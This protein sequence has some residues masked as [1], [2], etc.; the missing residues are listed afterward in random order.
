MTPTAYTRAMLARRPSAAA[1]PAFGHVDVAPGGRAQLHDVVEKLVTLVKARKPVAFHPDDIPDD[2]EILVAELKGFDSWFQP[3]APWSL[4]RAVAEIRATGS[5]LTLKASGITQGAWSFYVIRSKV[6]QNDSVVVRAKSPSW[7]L[8]GESRLLTKFV[9]SEL[10]LVQEPL[11]AFDRTADLVVIGSKVFVLD[12]RACE[13]L[14]VDADAVKRRAPQAVAT[15]K[16]KMDAGLTS[17][18]VDAVVRVCSND[19]NIARRVERLTRDGGLSTVTAT[20]VRSA[21]PDAGL[22]ANDF[23]PSGPLQAVTD[24]HAT[25]LV[26]I[27]A[28]LYYQPRF[29]TSPRRVAAYRQVR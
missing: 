2:G 12:P 22:T 25:V 26:D 23:G 4:E 19:A 5:P 14:L 21:L 9:G 6:G 29:S 10:K 8:K 16:Q 1:V 13:R 24:Q 18:T 17:K 28:D 7:G 27:V 20:E 15:F 3:Q 11:V